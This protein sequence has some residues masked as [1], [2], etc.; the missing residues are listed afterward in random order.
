MGGEN[1][2][3]RGVKGGGIIEECGS[4][5]QRKLQGEEV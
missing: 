4:A 2:G 5:T 3:E 1:W